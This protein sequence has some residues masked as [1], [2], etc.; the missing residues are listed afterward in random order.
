MIPLKVIA[1]TH[2]VAILVILHLYKTTPTDCSGELRDI[3]RFTPEIASCM[4][5]LQQ[6]QHESETILR[7]MGQNVAEK[8][9]AM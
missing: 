5:L 6:E 2:H 3:M 4:L 9:M 7:L 8:E 1:D